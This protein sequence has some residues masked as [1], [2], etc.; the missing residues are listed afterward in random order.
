M[1]WVAER[2]S[3]GGGHGVARKMCM[4]LQRIAHMIMV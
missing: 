2:V 4:K 3:L 1:E